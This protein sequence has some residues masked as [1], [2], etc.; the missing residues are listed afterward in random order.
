MTAEEAWRRVRLGFVD[1]VITELLRNQ[2]APVA[3]SDGWTRVVLEECEQ[4]EK[5]QP[6]CFLAECAGV[7]RML[8]RQ[9]QDRDATIDSLLEAQ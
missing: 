4:A 6:D 3:S 2:A 9:L 8:L 1:E 5:E 7:I